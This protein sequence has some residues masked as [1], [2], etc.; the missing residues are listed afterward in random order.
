MNSPRTIENT[1]VEVQAVLARLRMPAESL[2][3]LC[4]G[5]HLTVESEDG[6]GLRV[7]LIA[8]GVTIAVASIEV[9]EGSLIATIVNRGPELTGRR[10]DQWKHSKAMTTD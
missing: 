1:A 3:A 8:A 5:D 9:R 4:C 2:A 7:R 6:S 10:I